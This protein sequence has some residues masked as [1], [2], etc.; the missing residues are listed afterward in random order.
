MKIRTKLFILVT[1][2]IG[3]MLGSVSAFYVS[4][5]QVKTMYEDIVGN[6]K[7]LLHIKAIQFRLAGYSNDERAYLL[8]GDSKFLEQM[9]EK[10]ADVT[11]NLEELKTMRADAETQSILA[12][13]ANNYSVYIAAS[14]RVVQAY[15]SGNMAQARSTHFGE[16]RTARKE[17]DPIISDFFKSMEEKKKQ[18]IAELQQKSTNQAIIN[19]SIVIFSIVVGLVAGWFILRSILKPIWFIQA[20]LKNIAEGDGDLT[21]EIS[22]RANDELKELAVSFNQMMRSLR[23]LISQVRSG[24]EQVTLCVE[25]LNASTTETS[26]TAEMV[27]QNVVDIAEGMKQ[28]VTEMSQTSQSV[29]HM[30]TD[31]QHIASSAKAVADDAA[32]MKQLSDEGTTILQTVRAQM[33]TVKQ[34]NDEST[35]IMKE[36]GEQYASIEKIIDVI[37]KIATQT[38]LLALNAAI[39]SARA[40]EYGKGF[41]VVADEVRKL[42][43]ETSGSTQ[44]ISEIVR[45]LQAKMNQIVASMEKGTE[46]IKKGD[47]LVNRTG[48]TFAE[49]QETILDVTKKMTDISLATEELTLYGEQSLRLMKEIERVNDSNTNKTHHISASTQQQLAS[50]EEVSATAHTLAG[51]AETLRS[52]VERFKV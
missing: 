39:E 20:E 9:K 34:T 48:V 43:E 47:E 14:Q 38:N 40:G 6:D 45:S 3:V 13:I 36:L 11:T 23:E 24:A 7:M 5:K 44:E 17:L 1:L 31:V 41:A 37:H 49:I 16:E 10:S 30:V 26:R 12:K 29:H 35:R 51:M 50:F 32:M 8:T 15:Q 4:N 18:Q 25:E 21:K 22:W 52:R 46:E 2:L 19:I 42:A 28:Q 27:S 33:D